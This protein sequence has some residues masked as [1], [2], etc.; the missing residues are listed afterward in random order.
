MKRRH[1]LQSAIAAA[2]SGPLLGARA[3][4]QP[5]AQRDRFG[6]WTGKTFEATGFFRTHHDGD[7]WWLVTPEGHAFLSFGINHLHTG[8]WRQPYNS[9]AWE[10]RLGV[11]ELRGAEFNRAFREWFMTARHEFG[12]NTLGVHNQLEVLNQPPFMPYMLP[13]PFVDI[14]HWKSEVPDE[15][16][17]DVFAE[18]FVGHCDRLAREIAA[19]VADDPFLLAY[20]LTDC[21]LFTEEDCRAR[22]DVIGGKRRG[23]RI[24]WPRRLRNLGPAAPGKRAYVE[25]MRELYRDRIADFNATYETAFASFDDL[26]QS[27]NWRPTTDLSN[28]NETRDNV[29][30]LKRVVAQYY[31]TARDAIRRHDPHHLF[32]GDKLNANTDTVDTVLPVTARYT[33]LVFYQMY[34]EYG[35]QQQGLDR[36]TRVV[37]Q[38]FLNGDSAFACVTE[39]TPKPYGPV[40]FDQQ[41]RADWTREFIERVFARP[42]FVGWHYCGLI[43]T[44]KA[45][46]AGSYFERADEFGQSGGRQHT[47]LLMA[48]GAPYQPMQ[49]VIK[50]ASDQ[51]YHVALRNR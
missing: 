24:G 49:A 16:F 19:P 40:A 25:T 31:E 22:P 48:D 47:G 23:D 18:E 37:D 17:T 41:Q 10:Q 21:P 29:E 36:W 32:V 20:A 28:G 45:G 38:P 9:D 43:D 12:F 5:P 11:S 33:D 27:A 44:W 46:G 7:R 42:D 35:V 8:W 1:V 50:A 3:V 6:G 2:L 14:P 13:I 34:A 4:G 39:M 30:F 51:L 26:A 15:N